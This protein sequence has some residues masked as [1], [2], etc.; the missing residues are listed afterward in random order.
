MAEQP[1]SAGR[2]IAP[3]DDASKILLLAL[4]QCKPQALAARCGIPR[5]QVQRPRPLECG[6]MD[7]A[8][9]TF[10]PRGQAEVAGNATHPAAPPSGTHHQHYTSSDA[11]SH[12][13]K[14]RSD[15]DGLIEVSAGPEAAPCVLG[16]SLLAFALL[17]A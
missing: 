8:G 13:V 2:A 15:V 17:S 10:G 14:R 7:Q 12:P 4:E 11:A 3:G 5:Q 6:A 1:A 9:P 16:G